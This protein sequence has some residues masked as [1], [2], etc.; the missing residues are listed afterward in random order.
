M[1]AKTR[2]KLK[3]DNKAIDKIIPD[4]LDFSYVDK[5]GTNKFSRQMLIPFDVPKR[6]ILKGLKL[7]IQRRTG[8]KLFWL[9]FWF[10]NKADYY[11]VGKFI[12]KVFGTKEVEDKLLPIVR[13]H[14]N[15]KAHWIKKP[16]I[17]EKESERVIK[18]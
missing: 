17:T 13:Y 11:P 7:C 10:N 9:Q 18:K 1:K 5:N 12:P 14:T 3:F 2:S 6:S 15:D 16:N 4:E 8:S